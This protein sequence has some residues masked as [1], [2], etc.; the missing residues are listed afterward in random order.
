MVYPET[1]HSMRTWERTDDDVLIC[2]VKRY[3]QSEIVGVQEYV[4]DEVGEC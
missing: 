4:A 3:P 1:S 2:W